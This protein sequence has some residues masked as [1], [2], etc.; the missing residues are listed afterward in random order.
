MPAP[1][2]HPQAT[3]VLTLGLVGLVG[4]L[5]CY[6]PLL[7]SPVA[8]VKGA[9][10]KRE[11]E[12]D[13]MRWSGQDQVT[14]GYVT[15]IIGTV[16][17]GLAV[18]ALVVLIVVI[19]VSGEHLDASRWDD[20]AYIAEHCEDFDAGPM[21]IDLPLTGGA[22]PVGSGELPAG[23]YEEVEFEVEDLDDDEE[24]GS[25]HDSPDP[26]DGMSGG[27]VDPSTSAAPKGTSYTV[28]VTLRWDS[29]VVQGTVNPDEYRVHKPTLDEM[30]IATYHEVAPHRPEQRLL[31]L[32]VVRSLAIERCFRHAEFAD[33]F[34]HDVPTP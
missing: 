20:D 3:T 8:W 5:M 13:P 23:V 29:F 17:L 25:S 11:I 7:L 27:P 26:T 21:F 4:G 10:V 15:G 31:G 19:A 9:R 30:G 28:D 24:D 14:A 22:V 16:I 18:T 32:D 6:L 34:C 2:T 33:C 1:T 12:A